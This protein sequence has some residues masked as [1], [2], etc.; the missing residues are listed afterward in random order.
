M[1]EIVHMCSA[2]LQK[3]EMKQL[4]YSQTKFQ[5]KILPS[6]TYRR[7]IKFSILN[8][9]VDPALKTTCMTCISDLD[10]NFVQ[11]HKTA[12]L[13]K[14]DILNMLK[15][16]DRFHLIANTRRGSSVGGVSASHMEK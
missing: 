8:E 12:K 15:I 11:N 3:L 2:G 13:I 10:T 5:D 6:G 16:L 1:P 7:Q 14:K 4:K 9:N